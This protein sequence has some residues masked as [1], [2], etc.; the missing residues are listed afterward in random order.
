VPLPER[1]SDAAVTLPAP[2]PGPDRAFYLHGFASSAH[3]KKAVFFAE[4]LRSHGLGLECPDF[5][6][7]DFAS[8][9]IT[10]MLKAL[11]REI[12][13]GDSATAPAGS[14]TPAPIALIGSSLGA[15]IAMYSAARMPDRVDRLVLLAP[16]LT[17]A[18]D[19]RRFFTP[20]RVARWRTS[21]SLDVFHYGL[22]SMRSLNYSFYEDSLSYDAFALNVPQPIL[23]F[24]G[25]RDDAVDHRIV[26]KYAAGRPTVTLSLLDDDHQLL[27]SLP[28]IWH[29]VEPFLGLID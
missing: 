3:S 19:G 17:F 18:K 14:A 15:V 21:G 29:D 1:L 4:R 27:A 16:A 7:P 5:N 25:L 13:R 20:D 10:R 2:R 8:L 24:Q 23:I 12:R 26:E 11:E 6:E 28:R 22:G 9:T